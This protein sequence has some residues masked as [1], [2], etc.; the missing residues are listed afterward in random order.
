MFVNTD[1]LAPTTT[2][3]PTHHKVHLGA[4]ALGAVLASPGDR[5]AVLQQTVQV[6]L[7]ALLGVG[8][9]CQRAVFLMVVFQDSDHLVVTEVQRLFHWSVSPPAATG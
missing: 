9:S 5:R 6:L 4:V 7:S 3:P 8:V 1:G 2:T